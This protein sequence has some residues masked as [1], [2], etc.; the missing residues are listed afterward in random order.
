MDQKL[1][2]DY[3]QGE[4]VDSFDGAAGRLRYLLKQALRVTGSQ[5]R[6]ALNIGTGNGWLEIEA[7]KYGLETI[8]LDPSMI[9]IERV[10]KQ[11]VKGLVGRI[12]TTPYRDGT[13]DVVFC[14]EVLEH[15]TESQMHAGLD[16]IGRVLSP[17][18]YLIGSVPFN[19][20]L[21][22]SRVVCPDCGKVFHRWGHLQSFDVQSM[23]RILEG[24]RFEV[25]AARPHSFPFLPEISVVN[26]LKYYTVKALGRFGT[27]SAY[28]S[29]VFVARKR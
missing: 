19:E 14:S 5:R 22:K 27:P 11:C 18:G 3:F 25:L 4:G 28:P 29:L 13:F 1:I 21:V 2:W 15:L 7:R 10:A 16:E 8:S 26:F 17:G 20:T 12:E 6:L 24:H 9:A 23:T